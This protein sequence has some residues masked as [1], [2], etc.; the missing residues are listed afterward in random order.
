MIGHDHFGPSVVVPLSPQLADGRLRI[1]ECVGRDSA[2][3]TN[4]FRLENFKLSRPISATGRQFIR[5][6]IA[7][8]RGAALDRIQ[9][10]D[11]LSAQCHRP[12]DLVEQLAGSTYKRLS[13]S[14][15]VGARSL[16]EKDDTWLF[17]AYAKDGLGPIGNQ[18]RAGS[19]L[20]H[21]LIELRQQLLTFLKWMGRKFGQRGQI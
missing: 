8:L 15:L 20:L 21:L 2:E 10:V 4:E 17:V 5:L 19:A 11:I 18:L 13:L 7:I 1:E 3:A 6:R 16:A 12:D 14:V 9:D